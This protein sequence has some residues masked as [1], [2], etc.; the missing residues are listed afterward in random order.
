MS[1]DKAKQI[2]VVK[3][4]IAALE[5][6]EAAVQKKL[7]D[8]VGY[9]GGLRY[10][11]EHRAAMY[12]KQKWLNDKVDEHTRELTVLHAP[13]PPPLSAAD[14]LYIKSQ[15]L[16][17]YMWIASTTGVFLWTAWRQWSILRMKYA[18]LTREQLHWRKELLLVESPY[19]AAAAFRILLPSAV[20]F[21]CFYM[22]HPPEH[23]APP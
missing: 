4:H 12:E 10:S 2:D 22:M 9:F 16:A 8:S 1:A 3:Q 20:Y 18:P 14:A 17:G 11:R 13:P 21:M 23:T 5:A 7:D 6:T 19:P 15:Q